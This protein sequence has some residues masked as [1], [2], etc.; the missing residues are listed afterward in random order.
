MTAI[1]NRQLMQEIFDKLAI[2]D[3]S[4][5]VAHLDDNVEMRVTGRN[6]WSQTFRSKEQLIKNLY[7]YV[8]SLTNEPR[9]TTAVNIVAGDDHVVV[10]AR[11]A[12]SR[13]DGVRYDNEYCMVFKLRDGKIVELREYLDSAL[14][15][16]VLGAYPTRREPQAEIAD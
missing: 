3:G 9:T 11:G 15:E 14:C 16:N 10:E 12:M 5:F 8:Y 2:G 6:S 4:L 1:D 13:K 7:R